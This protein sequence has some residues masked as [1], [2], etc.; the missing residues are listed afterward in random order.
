MPLKL[1]TGEFPDERH[2]PAE[3]LALQLEVM[4]ALS[5]KQA[6]M[7]SPGFDT[8]RAIEALF[9]TISTLCEAL[10]GIATNQDLRVFSEHCGKRILHYLKH[11]RDYF[12]RTGRHP[13]EEW[14]ATLPPAPG[15][16]M[17]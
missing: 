1:S 10:P 6:E 3:L 5:A 7:P 15:T 4:R 2:D 16:L 9:A 12:E 8:G 17:N 14:G 13:I 11:H